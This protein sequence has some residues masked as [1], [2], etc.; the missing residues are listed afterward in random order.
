MDVFSAAVLLRET[1]L[2]P[3]L[4][5]ARCRAAEPLPGAP[6]RLDA[7]LAR[8]LAEDPS[9]RPAS[10]RAWLE[11]LLIAQREAEGAPSPSMSRGGP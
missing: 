2:G 11:G 1:W 3:G 4:D 5:D 7:H 6:P 10:G 9:D 8:A